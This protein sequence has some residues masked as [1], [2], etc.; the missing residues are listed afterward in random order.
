MVLDALEHGHVLYADFRADPDASP[1]AT[2][3]GRIEIF[4][5]TIAGFGFEECPCHPAWLAP[6]EWLGPELTER[7]PLHLIA[8]NPKT[9]LH[10]QLDMG[11]YS[12]SEKVQG[13]EPIR[14]N[15]AQYAG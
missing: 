7:F 3:S 15:P 6:R 8:N 13:R 1:L 14:M 9:R 10:G 5:E 12:Q 11:P 4:S 2:P